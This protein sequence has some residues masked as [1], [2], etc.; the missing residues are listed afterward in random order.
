LKNVCDE[1]DFKV[2]VHGAVPRL[3]TFLLAVHF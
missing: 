3:R 1:V 2:I